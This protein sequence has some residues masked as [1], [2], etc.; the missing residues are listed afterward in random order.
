[1]L[2]YRILFIHRLIVLSFIIFPFTV[3][4]AFSQIEETTWKL[5]INYANMIPLVINEPWYI[6][7]EGYHIHPA[8][9]RYTPGVKVGLERSVNNRIS[10]EISFLYGYPP[11]YLG[12]IDENSQNESRITKR[13]HFI[14][15]IFSPKIQFMNRDFG[16]FYLAPVLGYG[17][18]SEKTI[19]PSFGPTETWKGKSELVGGLRVGFDFQTRNKNVF[20]NTEIL[21]LSMTTEIEE[22]QT[23][24]KMKKTFGPFGILLGISYAFD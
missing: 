8:S 1:M 12:V 15:L 11:A 4:S 2:N 17:M 10:L 7:S 24:R 18:L 16:S 3:S 14:A 6:S 9:D 13:Y 19:T 21:C 5:N 22:Y 23:T 20:F